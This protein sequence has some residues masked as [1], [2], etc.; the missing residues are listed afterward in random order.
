MATKRHEKTL[1]LS[2]VFVLL[3]KNRSWSQRSQRQTGV[4]QRLMEETKENKFSPRKGQPLTQGFFHKLGW[5]SGCFLAEEAKKNALRP[6]FGRWEGFYAPTAAASAY[7][8]T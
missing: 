8:A 4:S 3:P 1:R 5:R 2:A 6:R 7:V